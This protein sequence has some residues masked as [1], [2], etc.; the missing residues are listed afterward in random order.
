MQPASPGDVLIAAEA[1]GWPAVDLG[2][3]VIGEGE[4][5][6]RAAVTP[7]LA[8][9]IWEAWHEEDDVDVVP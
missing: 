3:L 8:A 2:E 6:W 9:E 5:H 7:E 1:L 4:E